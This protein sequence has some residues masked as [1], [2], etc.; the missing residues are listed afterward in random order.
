MKKMMVTLLALLLV[1]L[2]GTSLMGCNGE[3]PANEDVYE[4]EE[5]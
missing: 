1:G 2:A 4:E 3:T 5:Q